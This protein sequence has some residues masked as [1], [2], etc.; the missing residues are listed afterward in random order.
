MN[1]PPPT[2]KIR[3]KTSLKTQS[4]ICV[5]SSIPL[6]LLGMFSLTG[7]FTLLMD[8]LVPAY[9]DSVPEGRRAVLEVSL[10]TLPAVILA[11]L[12]WYLLKK[13][14][15]LMDKYHNTIIVGTVVS[16]EPTANQAYAKVQGE[17]RAGAPLTDKLP[18]PLDKWPVSVGDPYPWT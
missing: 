18:V 11:P 8:K 9:T 1:Y 10:W 3:S 16:L 4:W 12:A 15:R 17:N 5:L 6:T 7:W 14:W 13:S 2:E